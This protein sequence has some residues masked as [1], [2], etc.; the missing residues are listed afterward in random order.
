VP[1]E[2]CP[3][4]T[5]NVRLCWTVDCKKRLCTALCSPVLIRIASQSLVT[6]IVST[7]GIYEH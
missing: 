7:C 4:G 5:R 1:P 6:Q 2:K 3:D